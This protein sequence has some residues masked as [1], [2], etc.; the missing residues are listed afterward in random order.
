MTK[1]TNRGIFV[2]IMSKTTD[3]CHCEQEKSHKETIIL[4][5]IIIAAFAFAVIAV[6]DYSNRKFSQLERQVS[7]MEMRLD[8]DE[9]RIVSLMEEDATTRKAISLLSARQTSGSLKERIARIET[10]MLYDAFQIDNIERWAIS[11]ERFLEWSFP[12]EVFRWVA[13][14]RP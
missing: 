14:G 2:A 13:D 8:A 11:V 10:S 4:T 9:R 12:V 3:M 1:P 6:A 5:A 7:E